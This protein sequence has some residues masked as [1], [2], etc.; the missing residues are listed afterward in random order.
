MV[1]FWGNLNKNNKHVIVLKWFFRQVFDLF[2][3]K[4][5]WWCCD[6]NT[7]FK[8]NSFVNYITLISFICGKIKK[9]Y[10]KYTLLAW[11]FSAN[12]W[13]NSPKKSW[14]HCDLST[15]FEIISCSNYLTM[16][17][18]L[19]WQNMIFNVNSR[20][21]SWAF[22]LFFCKLITFSRKK[23]TILGCFWPIF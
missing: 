23:I 4:L 12:F 16:M 5:S 21:L 10:N 6:F 11:F 7:F 19:S 2:Y 14:E 18:F 17:T 3:G 13:K 20:L 8:I 22:V 15:F 1:I 9:Y